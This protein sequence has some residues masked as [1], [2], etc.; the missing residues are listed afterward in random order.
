MSEKVNP[1]L[2]GFQTLIVQVA[3]FNE[4]QNVK[5]VK[6][7]DGD[8]PLLLTEFAAYAPN[9]YILPNGEA[10]QKGDRQ[11]RYDCSIPGTNGK[12]KKV[13]EGVCYRITFCR[14]SR[15]GKGSTETVQN[16]TTGQSEQVEKPGRWYT[17]CNIVG[18][19]KVETPE[20]WPVFKGGNFIECQ[21]SGD[22]EEVDI[23]EFQPRQRRGDS[24]SSKKSE[25]SAGDIATV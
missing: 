9:M 15:K 1:F 3:Q 18:I 7:G 5:Y 22:I 21:A 12:G 23:A 14:T 24:D 11:E 8:N 6:A 10:I 20:W 19:V 17:T 4:G 16:E 2:N 13:E 25:A